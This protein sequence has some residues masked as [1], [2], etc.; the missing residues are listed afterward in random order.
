[1]AIGAFYA[2]ATTLQTRGAAVWQNLLPQ[3]IGIRSPM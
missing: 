3:A 1:M 2:D